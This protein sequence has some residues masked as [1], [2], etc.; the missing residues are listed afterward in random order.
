MSGFCTLCKSYSQFFLKVIEYLIFLQTQRLLN[1]IS[2][3]IIIFDSTDLM[4]ESEEDFIYTSEPSE[5]KESEGLFK[6]IV[7]EQYLSTF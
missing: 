1:E 4:C 6:L 3:Y 7:Y 5:E 2:P